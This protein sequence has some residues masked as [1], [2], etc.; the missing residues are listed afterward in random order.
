VY[1]PE[2]HFGKDVLVPDVAS[3]ELAPDWI[4]A[5]GSSTP[6]SPASGNEG[7]QPFGENQ[8]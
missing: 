2:L 3:F 5:A 1:E 8:Y 7:I 6:A 4:C